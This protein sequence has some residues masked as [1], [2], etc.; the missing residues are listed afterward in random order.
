MV[1]ILLWVDPWK[2]YVKPCRLLMH[3]SLQHLG[4][5]TDCHGDSHL[6]VMLALRF[7]QPW[8]LCL[9]G[10]PA[11]RTNSYLA[12]RLTINNH[13]L[14]PH[15]TTLLWSCVCVCESWSSI[16]FKS[17]RIISVHLFCIN[18]AKQT[19]S[20]HLI[21]THSCWLL[22]ISEGTQTWSGPTTQLFILLTAKQMNIKMGTNLSNELKICKLTGLRKTVGRH[23]WSVLSLQFLL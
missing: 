7:L 2:D 20:V 17:Q 18:E 1:C 15:S 23:S 5:K 6:G 12:F 16:I 19:D 22:N 21:I 4:W 11:S 8:Q 14:C 13:L 10:A 3:R 9:A